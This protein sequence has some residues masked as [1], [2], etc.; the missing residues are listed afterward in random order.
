MELQLTDPLEFILPDATDI[1]LPA[2][3]CRLLPHEIDAEV[4]RKK[5]II[6]AGTDPADQK[7]TLITGDGRILVF[8]APKYYIPN[9]PAVPKD[10]GKQIFFE[11]I[12]GRWPCEAPGFYASSEWIIEKSESALTGAVLQVNYPYENNTW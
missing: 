3:V 2:Y 12:K 10:G 7:I 4:P 11:N 1:E 8:D 5:L 6:A 9:G